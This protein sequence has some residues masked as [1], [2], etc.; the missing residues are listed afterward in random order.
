VVSTLQTQNTV[1]VLY[2]STLM[3]HDCERQNFAGVTLPSDDVN[4]SRQ[5]KY[6][7]DRYPIF[8]S[9][10]NESLLYFL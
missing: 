1:I 7:S 6:K 9:F 2:A 10:N 4:S 3:V 8:T 5:E